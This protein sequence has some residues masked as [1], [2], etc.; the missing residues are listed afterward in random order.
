MSIKKT[1][2]A[3]NDLESELYNCWNILNDLRR[4]GIT[5][6]QVAVCVEYMDI[7]FGHLEE[8]LGSAASYNRAARK[9]YLKDGEEEVIGEDS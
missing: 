4:T 5:P 9:H 3:L 6:E 2:Y 8:I 1:W 7:K